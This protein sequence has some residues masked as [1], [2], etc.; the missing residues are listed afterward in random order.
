MLARVGGSVP[1]EPPPDPF[2]PPPPPRPE[3]VAPSASAPVV[4]KAIARA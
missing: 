4:R 3:S 2:G 1:E